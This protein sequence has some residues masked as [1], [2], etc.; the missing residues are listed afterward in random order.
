ME[1]IVQHLIARFRIG[2]YPEDAINVYNTFHAKHAD[3]MG[4]FER[5]Q[6]FPWLMDVFYKTF[7]IVCD[8]TYDETF[9]DLD[10]HV[11]RKIM[12][13]IVMWIKNVINAAL[14]LF[15]YKSQRTI[16]ELKGAIMNELDTIFY[17]LEA[18]IPKWY[19]EPM[20]RAQ[21]KFQFDENYFCFNDY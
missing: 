8:Y 1:E 5:F 17:A 16:T 7:R 13:E 2:D 12:N 10:D 15:G 11:E 19:C 3:D 20:Y 6:K 21:K 4:V 14:I 9:V 18:Q